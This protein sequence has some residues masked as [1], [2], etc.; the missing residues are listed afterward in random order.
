MEM[1]DTVSAYVEKKFKKLTKYYQ[2][3]TAMR[4]E[5]GMTTKH[6]HQGNIFFA[7]ANVNIPGTM[8][9]ARHVDENLYT[10]IDVVE[11]E[12][13]RELTEEKEKRV[14]RRRTEVT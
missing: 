10:A 6:H 11:N 8:F 12:L 2:Q 1:T 4:V 13:K 3:I 9:R 14:R 7:E 5:V